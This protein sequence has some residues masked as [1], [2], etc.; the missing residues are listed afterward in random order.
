M[1]HKKRQLV[2]PD[3]STFLKLPLNELILL[4]VLRL[5]GS[6]G[7]MSGPRGANII[8]QYQTL[9]GQ[10]RSSLAIACTVV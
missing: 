2:S 5:L 3:Q 1:L 9:V 4:A 7:Q 8:E 6:F 10:S